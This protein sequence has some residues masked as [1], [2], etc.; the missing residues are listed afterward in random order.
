MLF[1]PLQ[2]IG[3]IHSITDVS[4]EFLNFFLVRWPHVTYRPVTSGRGEILV[5]FGSG[6]I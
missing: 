6:E 5:P 2:T 1:L 3:V 4:N